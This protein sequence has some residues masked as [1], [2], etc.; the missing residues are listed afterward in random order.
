MY[1]SISERVSHLKALLVADTWLYT[2]PCRL[3]GRSVRQY[4]RPSL[5]LSHFW[6]LGG[7]CINY[8]SC[9]TVHNCLAVYP[10]LFHF[11][12]QPLAAWRE[13]DWIVI[14][15]ILSAW[16]STRWSIGFYQNPTPD[17]FKSSSTPSSKGGSV[18]YVLF[19]FRWFYVSQCLHW[20]RVS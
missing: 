12:R 16:P 9:P 1:A 15:E 19:I 10:A 5:G 2:L 17:S 7:F 3:V 13:W 8:C 11:S 4:V 20:Y 14:S 18:I 6:I